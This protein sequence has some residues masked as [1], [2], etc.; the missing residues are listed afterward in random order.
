MAAVRNELE[1]PWWKNFYSFNYADVKAR[2]GGKYPP[3]FFLESLT[4]AYA[5]SYFTRT[6]GALVKLWL[7]TGDFGRAQ[8]VL[9]YTLA[10][11]RQ[12]GLNRVPHYVLTSGGP[13]M[14][15]QMDGQ[16]SI[17]L[18]WALFAREAN[19]PSF[20]SATY[21]QVAALMDASMGPPYFDPKFGLVRNLHLEH[22]REERFWDTY[23]L[24][25]QSYVAQ[26]LREMVRVAESRGDLMHAKNWQDDQRI[27][28][29]AIAR[30][31]T[32]DLGGHKVYAEMF[33]N[34][35]TSQLYPGLSEFS[36]GPTAAGWAGVNPQVYDQTVAAL[37][38]YG[39]FMWNGHRVI[40]IGFT[41]DMTPAPITSGKVLAWQMLFFAQNGDWKQVEQTLA[42]VQD[43]QQLNREPRVFEASQVNVP[44]PH[45]NVFNGPGNGEQTVWMLYA[46]HEIARLAGAKPL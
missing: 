10:V 6:G 35:S 11:T 26:A 30:R 3:G 2:Q 1:S 40:S 13:E 23:D 18:A 21:N 28:E 8:D 20:V 32:W 15:D 24:L 39:S 38:R 43:E 14:T 37:L 45:A 17:I 46:L 25:T 44:P 27:L 19:A 31:M 12:A 22:Y 29:R 42:F 34:Q 41:Q 4:A 5:P 9:Q 7:S 16:A 36:F 33:E